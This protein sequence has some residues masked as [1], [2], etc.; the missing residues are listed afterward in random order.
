MPALKE[1]FELASSDA[2]RRQL[3]FAAR[4]VGKWDSLEFLFWLTT[5]H[6][7]DISTVGLV[8]WLPSANRRFT[9]LDEN[10]R[11]RLLSQIHEVAGRIP[12]DR[13]SRIESILRR[14]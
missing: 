6:R 5:V 12:D 3:S 4:L 7:W 9:S 11:V 10:T 13:W 14:S 8:R 1:A 2:A